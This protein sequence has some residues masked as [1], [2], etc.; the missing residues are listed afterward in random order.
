MFK[1][2]KL[3][4]L[5]GINFFIF[6]IF[7]IFEETLYRLNSFRKSCF[8]H[9]GY[10]KSANCNYKILTFQ[11][12]SKSSRKGLIKP[13]NDLGYDH[14]P[15]FKMV[16]DNKNSSWEPNSKISIDKHGL[17]ETITLKKNYKKVLTVGNS[18]TFG[19]QVSNES[20]WQSCLNKENLDYIFLNG[21]VNGYGTL[22]SI[23]RSRKIL[24]NLK[25]DS[26][27][28]STVLGHDF[29][30]DQMSLHNGLPSIYLEKNKSNQIKIVKPDMK[31]LSH[32]IFSKKSSASNID[33]LITNF[34][35]LSG[36]PH[37]ST[38][39]ENSKERFANREDFFPENAAPI[40]DVIMESIKMSLSIDPNVVWLLQYR[41]SLS[42]YDLNT[43]DNLLKLLNKNKISYIDTYPFL[44]SNYN[45]SYKPEE[46]W[47]GHHTPIGN[48]I[49]CKIISNSGFY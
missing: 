41:K 38:F 32:T 46:I 49:V 6:F 30:R 44:H 7:I 2:L 40:E 26:L 31:N 5:I 16:I 20:T 9:E 17:R 14:V 18:F 45:N 4:K 13:D 28:V 36:I 23:L 34:T 42:E 15:N 35:F 11:P 10:R 3:F 19:D 47:I 39:Y 27:L 8:I 21:G 22:Q 1:N 37:V 24:K 48:E 43:R 33:K 12:F 25:V 29:K